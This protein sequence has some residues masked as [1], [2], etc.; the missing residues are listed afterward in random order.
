MW[1]KRLAAVILILAA[2]LVGFYADVKVAKKIAFPY[3]TVTVATND[4]KLGLD[5]NGGTHLV[6]QADTSKLSNADVA[7][8]MTALRDVIERR[9]NM[10]G[11]SEPLVQVEKGGIAGGGAD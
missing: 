6:Y 9:V 3:V 2:V 7:E 1:K 11:V 5:L 8:S 10:F 4:Y